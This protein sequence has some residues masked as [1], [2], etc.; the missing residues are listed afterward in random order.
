MTSKG[1]T[2]VGFFVSGPR[3]RVV[4]PKKR[5]YR[6]FAAPVAAESVGEGLAEK[7]V[8]LDQVGDL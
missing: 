2:Q 7:R 5:I 6:P 1:N 4:S 8:A 3:R